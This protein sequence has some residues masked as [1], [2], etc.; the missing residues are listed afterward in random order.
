MEG[1]LGLHHVALHTRNTERSIEFYSLLGAKIIDQ[2]ITYIANKPGHFW[3]LTLLQVADFVMELKEPS[4]PEQMILSDE[5]F[6]NHICVKV[7]DVEKV[8]KKLQEKG[9]NTFIEPVFREHK[10]YSPNG[11]KNSF[12]RGPDGEQIE[13][14]EYR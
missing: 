14:I 10:I 13:L 11:L 5:G 8:V 1:I 3:K 6:F 2:T 4:F 9:V 12:F 7:D